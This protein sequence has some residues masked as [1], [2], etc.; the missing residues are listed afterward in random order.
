MALD[1]MGRTRYSFKMKAVF[2]TLVPVGQKNQEGI[3]TKK[4]EQA[5]FM[6]LCTRPFRFF[7]EPMV[8]A[9]EAIN[10]DILLE[11]SFDNTGGNEYRIRCFH[12]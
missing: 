9:G 6:N 7:G 1:S 10:H 8:G 4:V 5:L 12:A 11:K 3:D 2:W